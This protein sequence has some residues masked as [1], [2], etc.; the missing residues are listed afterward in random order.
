MSE[1]LKRVAEHVNTAMG[2]LKEHEDLLAYNKD[3]GESVAAEQDKIAPLKS[4][5][6]KHAA[7][8]EKRNIQVNYNG[9]KP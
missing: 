1:V 9:V 7:A 4:K 6:F 8:L 5:L 2:L 3:A